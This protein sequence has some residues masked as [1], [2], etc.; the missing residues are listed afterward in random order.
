MLSATVATAI[1][2]ISGQLEALRSELGERAT[3]VD[4]RRLAEAFC[5]M[6]DDRQAKF[7]VEC[8]RIM[9]AWP[10]ETLGRDG[11]AWYIG[12]HLATCECATESGRNLLNTI[13][14]AMHYQLPTKP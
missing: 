11:Q 1:E 14:S 7:F 9:D 4:V 12:R 2:A 3:A 10:V 6:D 8:A 5:R 13:H